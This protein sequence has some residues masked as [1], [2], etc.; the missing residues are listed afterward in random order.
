MAAAQVPSD[1]VLTVA[2]II[3]QVAKVCGLLLMDS[4]LVQPQFG[5]RAERSVAVVAGNP[6]NP[7]MKRLVSFQAV[8][9]SGAEVAVLATV[10]FH[11]LVADPHVLLHASWLLASEVAKLAL[12]VGSALRILLVK[13][14]MSLKSRRRHAPKRAERALELPWL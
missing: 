12:Q 10:R 3:A 9:P 2:A 5:V 13:V 8:P 14:P 4:S 11:S 1:I 7:G 6:A